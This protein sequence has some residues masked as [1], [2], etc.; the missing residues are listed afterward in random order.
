M[1]PTMVIP[2]TW[3]GQATRSP[4]TCATPV[5]MVEVVKERHVQTVCMTAAVTEG[6]AERLTAAVTRVV[7]VGLNTVRQQLRLVAV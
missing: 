5:S 7:A 2:P 3:D 1:V 6:L 4:T